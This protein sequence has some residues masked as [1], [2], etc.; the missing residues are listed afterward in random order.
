MTPQWGHLA[1]T[2]EI[3][4]LTWNMT[5]L[6]LKP[7]NLQQTRHHCE[8]WSWIQMLT[9]SDLEEMPDIQAEHGH[10]L[11]YFKLYQFKNARLSKQDRNLEF[12]LVM[13]NSVI[14]YW[15]NVISINWMQTRQHY[16]M[17]WKLN[18]LHLLQHTFVE[19]SSY[20][21]LEILDIKC[22]YIHFVRHSWFKP[23]LTTYMYMSTLSWKIN[24]QSPWAS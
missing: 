7:E 12:K 13:I 14:L 22:Y 17:Q 18:C 3:W 8:R 5:H 9:D 6:T 2:L 21:Y 1:S 16:T 20:T 10:L 15:L 4:N 24:K 23:V 19:I 11:T